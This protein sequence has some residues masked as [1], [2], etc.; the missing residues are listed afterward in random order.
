MFGFAKAPRDPL[1]DVRSAQRWVDA[2]PDSDPLS[3]HGP[4]LAELARVPLP[5]FVRNP[6]ALQALFVLDTHAGAI[7]RLLLTQYIEHAPRSGKL[8]EQLWEALTGLSL[9]FSQAYGAFDR[10]IAATPAEEWRALLPELLLREIVQLGIDAQIRMFRYEQWIPAK[11][12]ELHGRYT[13]ATAGQFERERVTLAGESSPLT[14][15]QKYIAVLV[16]HLCNTGN[17]A[18]IEV[19]WL[20]RHLDE[21]CRSLAL[22]TECPSP[23]AFYVDLRERHGLRR[24]SATP[25]EGEVLFVDTEPLHSL[26]QH[27][28]LAVEQKVRAQP[29]SSRT[30]RRIERLTLLTKLAAQVDP[31]FRPLPRRGERIAAT[32]RADAIVGFG[33][34]SDYLHDEEHAVLPELDTVGTFRGT[35]DIAVFGRLR[36][37][38]DKRKEQARRRLASFASAGGPWEM[39][40]VSLTGL[41][42]AVPMLAA[43]TL[44]LGMLVALRAEGDLVWKVGIVRRMRRV[45]AEIA[46]VG[47][48]RIADSAATVELRASRLVPA[49]DAEPVYAVDGETHPRHDRA[50]RGLFLAFQRERRKVI[51]S[52]VLPAGDYRA[53]SQFRLQGTSASYPIR[54]GP[55]IE[56]HSEWIWVG[57]EQLPLPQVGTAAPRASAL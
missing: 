2:F 33:R 5:G 8:E 26:L 9:G 32:G 30:P 27:Y 18:R 15:E 57:V 22:S 38:Q 48:Q 34:I 39:K 42:V 4:L 41:R 11:W 16:L 36:N 29:L 7:R 47:L 19:D 3:A 1:A 51:Q 35:L 6:A 45:T 20:A 56:K 46:E 10:D 43:G 24:R 25:L 52:L 13:L 31:E 21:W 55:V 12:V 23:T 53:G 49:P 17:L 37:E 28:I 44:T 54:L 50:F 14:I 40:D